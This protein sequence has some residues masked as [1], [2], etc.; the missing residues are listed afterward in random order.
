MTKLPVIS[1][2]EGAYRFVYLNFTTIFRLAGLPILLA[3]ILT[4]IAD[5]RTLAEMI[6]AVRSAP[7]MPAAQTM[8]VFDFAI[9]FAT[10]CLYAYAA[11]GLHRL[12]LFHQI[13]GITQFGGV[14]KRF[15]G[16]T[17]A[18]AL[19]LMAPSVVLVFLMSSGQAPGAGF[20]AAVVAVMVL[21]GVAAVLSIRILPAY[22]HIVASGR[23]E[24]GYAW[25][26]SRGNW[27]RLVWMYVLAFLPLFAV[28]FAATPAVFFE[29][30]YMSANKFVVALTHTRD[31]L[32]LSA[33]ILYLFTVPMTG[34]GVALLCNA[35][36]TFLGLPQTDPLPSTPPA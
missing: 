8:S 27:W 2:I 10:N 15:I 29:P 6:E 25:M 20:S 14:E 23:L 11:V 17:L 28:T 24:L 22:P 26:L 30:Q 12:A 3:S 33:I 36:K 9:T 1:T 7:H 32:W 16:L 5:R 19:T 34:L 21:S 13:S 31:S 4:Y 35:Y 18:V